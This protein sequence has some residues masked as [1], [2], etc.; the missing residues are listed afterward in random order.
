MK[1]FFRIYYFK[2]KI[3]SQ[4]QS[5]SQSQTQFLFLFPTTHKITAILGILLTL[6][7]ISFPTIAHFV[8]H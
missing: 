6:F 3:Y 1:Y 4:S 2:T 7:E 8:Q 5:Y